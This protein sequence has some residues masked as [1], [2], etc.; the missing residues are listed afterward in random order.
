MQESG[1]VSAPVFLLLLR[2]RMMNMK[3]QV[4]CLLAIG[5]SFSSCMGESGEW[6]TYGSQAGVVHFIPEKVIQ[7]RSGNQITSDDFQNQDV[8]EGDCCLVDFQINHSEQ[9]RAEEGVYQVNMLN[10]QP[11]PD[12]P[13]LNYVDTAVAHRNE[14]FLDFEVDA[15]LYVD[16]HLFLFPEYRKYYRSQRDSFWMSYDPNLP[17]VTDEMTGRRCFQLYLRST[18]WRI[19]YTD[20]VFTSSEITTQAFHI[21]EFVEKAKASGLITGDS[22]NFQLVY[23]EYFLSEDSSSYYWRTSDIYT[24]DLDK[25]WNT[26]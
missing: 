26:W 14:S 10:Y 22:L 5:C 4:F 17:V 7:L 12:W 18:T 19:D 21:E 23:P 9:N 16:G 13:L 24:I 8:T 11:V 1:F 15:T 3:E 2:R 25:D 20:T 6:E